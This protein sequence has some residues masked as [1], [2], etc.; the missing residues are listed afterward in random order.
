M[1]IYKPSE[2]RQFLSGLGIQPKKSLSQNFL[3]DGNI[4]RKIVKVSDISKEDVILEIGPGPGSLTEALLE[5][6]AK[7][8]AVERDDVLAKALER[9]QTSEKNLQI[10]CEDILMFPIEETLSQQLKPLQKAKVVA[11]LP[12]HLTTIILA[13]LVVMNRLFSSLVLMVQEEVARRFTAKP[14]TSDYGSFTL[15]LNFYC[16]PKYGFQVSK[17][18]FYPIPNVDSAIVLLELKEPP[19]VS[20]QE[21]FFEMTRTAFKH[22]RKMLRSSLRDLYDPDRIMET[23]KKIECSPQARPEELSLDQF[24]NFFEKITTDL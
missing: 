23:L 18:C 20:N 5:S 19:Y 21:K 3:I 1:P 15:F 22:R 14:G 4:I 2:L 17:N 16:R 10:F 12:Y 13:R 9:L 8:L 11:N 6:G 7:V 24:L